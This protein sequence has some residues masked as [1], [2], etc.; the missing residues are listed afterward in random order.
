MVGL[1]E[2]ESYALCFWGDDAKGC[3][4]WVIAPNA[5]SRVTARHRLDGVPV[6]NLVDIISTRVIVRDITS[7]RRVRELICLTSTGDITV[8]T[9]SNGFE[10]DGGRKRWEWE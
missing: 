2:I 3:K 10:V 6:T 7:G 9:P 8:S 1:Y 5:T 4:V